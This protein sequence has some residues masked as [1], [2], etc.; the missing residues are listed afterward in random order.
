MHPVYHVHADWVAKLSPLEGEVKAHAEA[1]WRDL[2]LIDTPDF[3]SV[4]RSNRRQAERVFH[5]ADVFLFITDTQKYADL[6]TWEYLERILGEGKPAFIVLNKVNGDTAARDFFARLDRRGEERSGVIERIL[7]REYALDDAGLVPAADPG[8]E[9]LRRALALLGGSAPERGAIL[10]AAFRDAYSRVE[11]LWDAAAAFLRDYMAGLES[12]REGLDRRCREGALSLE[13]GTDL[14]VDSGL[15]A[16]VYSRVQ[17]RLARL[18]LLR[19]P[20]RLL[21][22]P[23]QGLRNLYRRLRPE[24]EAAAAAADAAGPAVV[25]RAEC[26]RVL[27]RTLIDFAEGARESFTAER[28]CPGLLPEEEFHALRPGGEEVTA[29]YRERHERF[30]A[31][32]GREAKEAAA[33]LTGEHKLK[34]ILS[35]VLY[36]GVVVG[37]QIHTAGAF[38]LAELVTDAVI[39]P[40]VAKAVGIALS[41]ERVV[42]FEREAHREFHRLLVEILE[43]A[44]RR[45]ARRLEAAGAFKQAFEEAAATM[46]LLRREAPRLE[47]EFSAGL[48]AAAGAAP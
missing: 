15:K 39:S 11:S 25:E 22:L 34:F 6:A 35:Q 2:V 46:E 16:E 42:Q 38:T 19:Y 23:W 41:S 18:D 33:T 17:E 26:F 48:P 8:M 44:R 45:F 1:A 10:T 47:K 9:A 13:V 36:N 27:E 4:E 14:A 37:V 43:E 20:R 21:A 32:L 7:V 28:R 3:D 40:L 12:L 31:W 30:E 24:G 29:L 5:E